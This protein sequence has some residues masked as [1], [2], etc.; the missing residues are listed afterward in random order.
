MRQTTQKA[1]SSAGFSLLEVVVVTAILTIIMGAAFELMNRSQASFDRNQLLAEAHQ[2]ADFAIVRVTE[3]VRG[4]G[5]SPN[6]ATAGSVQGVSNKETDASADNTELI[7]IRSDLDGDTAFDDRVDSTT[8][9]DAKYYILSSEDITVK[10]FKDGD[11]THDIPANTLA[12]VDNT[13]DTGGSAIQGVPFVL[14]EHINDFKA[15]ISG[16]GASVTLTIEA[17]PSSITD[18]TDPRWVTFTRVMQVRLR[19]RTL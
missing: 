4:A 1:E 5:A 7:R 18:P 3:L 8:T 9:T 15:E 10:F 16:D 6:G 12:L 11:A 17:G 19:N 13:P 14:A 2:N